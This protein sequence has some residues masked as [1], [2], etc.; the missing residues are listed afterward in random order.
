[1]TTTPVK[2]KAHPQ[3]DLTAER[4]LELLT[5]ALPAA[6]T[7]LQQNALAALRGSKYSQCKI[8]PTLALSDPFIKAIGYMSSIPTVVSKG[9]PTLPTL[10]GESARAIVEACYLAAKEAES[11]EEAASTRDQVEVA[12]ERIN[13]EIFAKGLN[14]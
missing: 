10:V 9:V 12:L 4:I 11:E 3:T 8:F 6:K 1:M 2:P 7:E 5:G 13:S 14:S